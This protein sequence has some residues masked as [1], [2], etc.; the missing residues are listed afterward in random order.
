[1]APPCPYSKATVLPT[2]CKVRIPACAR[3]RLPYPGWSTE[4]KGCGAVTRLPYPH[5]STVLPS[6]RASACVRLVKEVDCD[7]DLTV[8][9]YVKV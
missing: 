8:L 1:D 7:C 9:P 6:T 5:S 2:S 3:A 4:R